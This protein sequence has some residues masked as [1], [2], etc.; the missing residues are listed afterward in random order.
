M[1]QITCITCPIGCR[2]SIETMNG[3]Y[4]I[5]GNKCAKGENFVMTELTSPVRSLTTTVRTAFADVP[6]LPVKTKG[7]V[8]KEK[9]TEIMHELSKITITER[10]GIGE[11]V[12][13]NIS[14][15]NCDI[16]ATSDILKANSLLRK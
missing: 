7:E 8:P 4:V 16:I 1:K 13:S 15:T 2:I 5:S 10:T 9:I 11:T 3:Q 12:V 6:A 14:G